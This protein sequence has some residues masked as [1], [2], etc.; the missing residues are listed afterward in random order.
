SGQSV[1]G[2][3]GSTPGTP[4]G[5][6]PASAGAQREAA[7]HAEPVAGLPPGVTARDAGFWTA[8]GETLSASQRLGEHGVAALNRQAGRELL[9]AAGLQCLVGLVV[10]GI[11]LAGWGVAAGASALA[12]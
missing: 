4:S 5:E 3:A 2:Q 7:F 11:C 9:W 1:N 6:M 8:T 10:S 12:G